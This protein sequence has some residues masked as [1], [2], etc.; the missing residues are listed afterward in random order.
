MDPA[1][2]SS[3]MSV[4]LAAH[5]IATH[6]ATQTADTAGMVASILTGDFKPRLPAS[7]Q[8]R[9]PVSC[10]S[11]GLDST[12]W[13]VYHSVNRLDLCNSSMFLNF[14]LFNKLNN[15]KTHIS[16]AACTADFDSSSSTTA[17]SQNATCF[18]GSVNQSTTTPLELASS[19]SKS[20][21]GVSDVVDALNQL[22]SFF[23][24]AQP[25]CSNA[26]QIAYSGQAAVGVFVGSGLYSQ[27]VIPSVLDKLTTQFET[28]GA[29]AEET[30]IQTCS[31]STSRY[32]LGVFASAEGDLVSVQKA[33][34]S[35]NNGSCVS[36]MDES[37]QKW[38][39]LS[40]S[41]PS[42]NKNSSSVSKST[43]LAERA[44]LPGQK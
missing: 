35:W 18:P 39:T 30:L 22:Q 4:Y 32:S 23:S 14:N 9:Y 8:S 19:G 28:H 12:D 41:V 44:G 6:H 27:G 7:T 36:S 3:S 29:I 1:K 25:G 26:I 15:S 13:S 42:S 43:Y 37:T 40:F 2:V 24:I 38:Q 17:N 5:P 11:S 10:C 20:S 33:I 31:D 16:I 34:Q 21:T